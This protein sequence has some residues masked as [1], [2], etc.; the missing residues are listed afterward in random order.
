MD[1]TIMRRAQHFQEIP[2]DIVG[3]TAF[4]RYNKISNAQT[5]NMI[6]SDNWLVPY[7]GYKSIVNLGE[8]NGGGRGLFNSARSGKLIVVIY[9]SVYTIDASFIYTKIGEIDTFS[10]DVFI[11]ENDAKQIAICDKKDIWIYNYN[12][13]TFT[14]ASIDF[15]PG[16]IAFQDGY[17]ISPDSSNPK[18]RLSALNDGISWPAA[19]ANIGLFQTK[20]DNVVACVRLPGRG[21]NLLVMGK[22]VSELWINVGYYLFPYQRT[23][24]FN[25]DY[26]CLN[27]ATI[28]SGENFVVWIGSNE[29]SGPVIMYSSGGDIKQIST[30]GINFRLSKLKHPEEAYA[31]LFKQDGHLIYQFTFPH[32]D[33]NASYAYDFNTDKFF[34]LCDENMNFHIAKRVVAFANSYYFVSFNDSNVYELNS[35]YTTLDG[36]EAVRI[37]IGQTIRLPDTS[38][39]IVNNMVFP[40]EQG[41]SSSIQRVDVSISTDGGESFGNIIGYTLNP[42]GVRQNRLVS[43]VKTRCNEFTPQFRFWGDS[44]FVMTNGV[45]SIYQ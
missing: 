13:N 1:N 19:P 32:P 11:D 15:T 29:K 35:E 31:F 10:G 22:T 42:L 5:W 33:D 36:K 43:W 45:M 26:G 17:F 38:P 24:G 9:D 3:S 25:I 6:I 23:S 8:K 30:D 18:W 37:R 4:G 20:P 39:F 7:A 16:Y 44:R 40:I 28:A 27:P 14:K 12:L 34:N 21:N 41:D 2:L